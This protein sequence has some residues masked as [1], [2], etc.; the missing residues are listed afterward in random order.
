MWRGSS[1]TPECTGATGTPDGKR[2]K[3]E[4]EDEFAEADESDREAKLREFVAELKGSMVQEVGQMVDAKFGTA[5]AAM[6]EF[7]VDANRKN[8]KRIS[9]M[10]QEFSDLKYTQQQHGLDNKS[11][12]E[13]IRK[14]ES[15]VALAESVRKP[16]PDPAATLEWDTLD[17][18][19]I[20]L[21]TETYVPKASVEKLVKELASRAQVLESQLPLLGGNGGHGKRVTVQLLGEF[22]IG[23]RRA[24]KIDRCLFTPGENGEQG[25]WEEAYVIKEDGTRVKCFV[26]L[27][28]PRW[29][30]QLERHHKIMQA[31]LASELCEYKIVGIK[32]DLTVLV[33]GEQ[34]FSIEFNWAD[35]ST[36]IIWNDVGTTQCG[37]DR[38]KIE[39]QFRTQV[40][41]SSR[42]RQQ[43]RSCW[44]AR[45]T[46]RSSSGSS[47][48]CRR[49][50]SCG[51]TGIPSL[52][53]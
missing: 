11:I 39:E 8:D 35:K 46:F 23:G 4:D 31:V 28:K 41:A 16:L 29:K 26:A 27:D 45:K 14:L 2:K 38:A 52:P 6:Q 30:V 43:P 34:T 50:A 53:G 17:Q 32:R 37:A 10:E 48:S 33:G 9:K 47:C 44:K 1:N 19:I 12:W 15:T 49:R 21:N 18:T 25:T 13:S 5:T 42:Q 22:G 7:V 40:Q 20:R 36:S 3:G 24:A 51:A